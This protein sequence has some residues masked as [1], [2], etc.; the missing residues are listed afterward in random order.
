MATKNQCPRANEEGGL[1]KRLLRWLGAYAKHVEC[2]DIASAD[3]TNTSTPAQIATAISQSAAAIPA[4]Q[5]GAASGVA[6][7]GA[8]SKINIIYMPDVLR[9]FLGYFASL[10]ALQAAYPTGNAGEYATVAVVGGNDKIYIWDAGAGA[11]VDSGGS[12]AVASVNGQT[13]VVVLNYESVGAASTSDARLS[14]ERVP[15][16]AGIAAKIHAAT[17]KTTPVDADELSLWDSVSQ[18]LQKLTWANLKVAIRT[19]LSAYFLPADGWFPFTA[20]VDFSDQPGPAAQPSAWAANTAYAIGDKVYEDSTIFTCVVAGTSHAATEPTW[21]GVTLANCVTDNT[22][23]WCRGTREVTMLADRT[24]DIKAGWQIKA[25]VGASYDY[26]VVESCT[27][28]LLVLAGHAMTTA[29]GDLT[30][31]Y[32]KRRIA[33]APIFISGPFADSADSALNLN[34]QYLRLLKWCGGP[35]HIVKMIVSCYGDDTG[36]ASPNVDML[37]AGAHVSTRLAG[38]GLNVIGSDVT[39]VE[40][41]CDINAT[42]ATLAFKTLLETASDALGTNDDSTNLLIQTM[43]VEE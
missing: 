16:A 8:D 27:A 25:K 33:Q 21:S 29:D 5:K 32:V 34:D 6:P 2:D 9:L 35:A 37:A 11:W 18:T 24:A 30:E 14:D 4:A 22:V 36:A 10:A 31:L 38:V 20:N 15:T 17:S 41:Y 19:Y 1:G 39:A 13:G 40:S 23:T 42:N 26:Y 12:G 28:G 3:G 7:L 43:I